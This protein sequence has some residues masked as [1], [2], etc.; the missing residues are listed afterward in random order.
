MYGDFRSM[1][2]AIASSA[3]VACSLDSGVLS[4]GCAVRT[5]QLGAESSGA[6]TSAAFAQ[7]RSTI[8]G[9]KCVPRRALAIS[10][11]ASTPLSRW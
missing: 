1:K 5:S 9:S 10:T 6:S 11:A 3:A 2:S 4:A 8:S 7:N